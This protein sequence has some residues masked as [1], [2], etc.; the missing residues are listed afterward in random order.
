MQELA[1]LKYFVRLALT[2]F[3]VVLAAWIYVI[4]FPMGF[5]EHGYPS[6][7][8]KETM[9]R[10]CR[11]GKI[12]FFGDSQVEASIIPAALPVE[13]TNF[14]VPA[15]TP[16][17]VNTAVRHAMQCEHPPDYVVIALAPH[18]F[19]PLSQFFWVNSLRYGFID[20][21]S[22]REIEETANRVGDNLTLTAAK[23]S[24][25]L[26]GPLRDWLYALHFPS[27]YFN[28]LLQGQ[29]FG[30]YQGNR[31]Q[32]TRVLADRGFVAYQKQ[33]APNRGGGLP[34][35]LARTPL[36]TAYFERTLQLLLDRGVSVGLMRTPIS[37]LTSDATD[38]ASEADFT[39]YLKSLTVRFPNVQLIVAHRPRWP[40]AVFADAIHLDAEGARI[41]S[42]MLAKCV[43]AGAIRVGCDLAWP[44]AAAAAETGHAAPHRLAQ[45]ATAPRDLDGALAGP[46]LH[47]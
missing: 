5:L 7:I 11:L 17:E 44:G 38:A 21:S 25:G 24:D 19:T 1:P 39:D 18:E 8:A 2:L 28:N 29:I 15:G 31:D 26:S 36:L 45:T 4:S 9:L 13:S 47:N 10:D 27:L 6:W 3:S 34:P 42:A 43:E 16:L 40:D 23:T 41:F 33:A 37:K 20:A 46:S 32:L 14:G 30:R 12:S 35:N 22:L